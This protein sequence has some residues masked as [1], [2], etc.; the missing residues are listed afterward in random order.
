MTDQSENNA[1]TQINLKRGEQA[2]LYSWHKIEYAQDIERHP[3]DALDPAQ[4]VQ[5]LPKA[6]LAPVAK[7]TLPLPDHPVGSAATYAQNSAG[8]PS[9]AAQ[10]RSTAIAV[11]PP[12]S[13]PPHP[14]SVESRIT[15][16]SSPLETTPYN[17]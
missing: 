15:Q 2:L 7:D 10:Q 11:Q 16:S 1:P 4:G 14:E 8:S 5:V 9:L 12:S 6:G 13:P 3:T 17:P